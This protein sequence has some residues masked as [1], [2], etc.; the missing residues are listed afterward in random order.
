M[1]RRWCTKGS[2]QARERVG[3]GR[4]HDQI[5]LGLGF[6]GVVWIVRFGMYR[7]RNWEGASTTEGFVIG[8]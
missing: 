7:C 6:G 4:T 8:S 2:G 5:D 1:L 3:R